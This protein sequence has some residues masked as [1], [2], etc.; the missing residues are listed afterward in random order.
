MN[1]QNDSV[2]AVVIHQFALVLRD[3]GELVK[4]P[5]PV[6]FLSGQVLGALIFVEDEGLVHHEL[7]LIKDRLKAIYDPSLLLGGGAFCIDNLDRIADLLEDRLKQ[8]VEH[9][10]AEI[11]SDDNGVYFVVLGDPC[12][13]R[14]ECLATAPS[15][16]TPIQ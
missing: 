7:V 15:E 4:E 3:T 13:R 12:E 6:H 1:S 11:E 2:D 16:T 9:A 14:E 10:I 8:L 5:V